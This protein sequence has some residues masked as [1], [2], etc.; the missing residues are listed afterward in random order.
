[1]SGTAVRQSTGAAQESTEEQERN[2]LYDVAEHI[3]VEL[4][5]K[6]EVALAERVSRAALIIGILG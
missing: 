4:D 3:T 1:V 5:E 2:E 6:V